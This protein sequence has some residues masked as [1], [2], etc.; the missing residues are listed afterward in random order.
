MNNQKA[1]AAYA[2][3][4]RRLARMSGFD[5]R[6]VL[7]AESGSILK[8]WAGRT[9][10]ARPER[11]RQR[12]IARALYSITNKGRA[13]PVGGY[14]TVNSGVRGGPA[15]QIWFRT[16]KNK[17]QL[18][19]IMALPNTGHRW[20]NLHYRNDDWTGIVAG[21][22]KAE[23]AVRKLVPLAEKSAN[24]SRQSVVQIA[25]SLGI[26]L[27]RVPG[28]G[29]SG[30]GLAKARSAMASNG[31]LYRNGTS[32]QGGNDVTAYV[33]LINRLPYG[34]KIGMDRVLAGVVAGRARY[35]EKSYEKGAFDSVRRVAAAFPGLFIL[36]GPA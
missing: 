33:D 19:G 11:V 29:I 9:K 5:H 12:A 17:F 7:R 23:D 26:D 31:V 28:G 6:T 2:E 36:K 8:Q 13:S 16:R 35:I 18:A 25:D 24:L 22:Q 1:T 10:V 27:L 3:A 4:F 30:A 21:V 34:T 14:V 20:S 32:G 15:G